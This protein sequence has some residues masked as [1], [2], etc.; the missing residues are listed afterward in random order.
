[1]VGVLS[2]AAESFSAENRDQVESESF[3]LE[4]LWL[5]ANVD[6]F[7]AVMSLV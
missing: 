3:P 6:Y 1:M 2:A 5:S 7:I 4:G